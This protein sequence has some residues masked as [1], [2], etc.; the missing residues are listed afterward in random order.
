MTDTDKAVIGK[1]I[2]D[3]YDLKLFSDQDDGIS[4]R[5]AYYWVGEQEDRSAGIFG[6]AVSPYF[7]TENKAWAWCADNREF[8]DGM[9]GDHEGALTL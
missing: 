3:S 1:E 6:D 5:V 9:F 8:L 4:C 7:H 2:A